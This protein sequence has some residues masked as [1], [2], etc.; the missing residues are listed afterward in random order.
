MAVSATSGLV[1]VP[2][3]RQLSSPADRWARGADGKSRGAA[4]CPPVPA[5]PR[6]PWDQTEEPK[7]KV[8]T[9]RTI[10]LLLPEFFDPQQVC[11]S[12]KRSKGEYSNRA[13]V[14]PR[15]PLVGLLSFPLQKCVCFSSVLLFFSHVVFF[16]YYYWVALKD[17]KYKIEAFLIHLFKLH[18]KRKV[19]CSGNPS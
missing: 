5:A 17:L 7:P 10:V 19:C 9:L 14:W 18:L 3:R 13:A 6:P 8:T 1:R 2:L 11:I 4:H 15:F 12:K 16:Y